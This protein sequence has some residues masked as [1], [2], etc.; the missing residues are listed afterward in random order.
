M[1]HGVTGSG[2]TE[3]YLRLAATVRAP[4]RGV[5]LLVPEIA[6]TPAVAALFR[7]RVRRARRDPAQRALGRRAPRSVAAH[8]P[9]RRRRRRRHAL[10]GVRAARAASG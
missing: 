6:L 4:G 3:I 2:K 5:L 1:L 8:P 10:G 7:A 9:R